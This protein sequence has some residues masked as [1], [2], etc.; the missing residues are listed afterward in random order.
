MTYRHSNAVRELEGELFDSGTQR[1]IMIE[2]AHV[3]ESKGLIRYGQNEI[4][5]VTLLSRVTIANEMKRLEAKGLIEKEKHGRYKVTV[6]PAGP[7]VKDNGHRTETDL[8]VRWLREKEADGAVFDAEFQEFDE[9]K[10]VVIPN[11]ESLP[12]Y[13]RQAINRDK[14]RWAFPDVGATVYAICFNY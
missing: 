7:V 4:A 3:A 1:F 12:D 14:L 9:E 8:L 5:L 11:D 2:L 10:Q 13:V 6:E